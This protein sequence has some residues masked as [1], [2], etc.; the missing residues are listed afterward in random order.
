MK[1]ATALVALFLLAWLSACVPVTPSM[2]SISPIATPNLVESFVNAGSSQATA[3][4]AVS[5]AQF[6][7]GQLTATIQSQQITSTERAWSQTA[8]LQSVELS[9]TQESW[10]ATSM[11][12]IAIATAT[13]ASHARLD[14]WLATATQHAWNIT[15]TTDAA[16]AQTY[17]TKQA[18]ESQ[19]IQLGLERQ[20]E[21]NQT[22]A[23]LPIAGGTIFSLLL[24]VVGFNWSRIRVIQRDAHGDAPLLINVMD[25]LAYDADRHP[26]STAGLL[27]GDAKR[28]PQLTAEAQAATTARD[29][30]ID[31]TTRSLLDRPRSSAPRAQLRDA[32]FFSGELPRIQIVEP[33]QVQPLLGDVLPQIIQDA[34]EDDT[35]TKTSD[36]E[37][38]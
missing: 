35:N 23:F 6:F 29:Q 31:L 36:Q 37:V 18:G 4:A 26:S 1:T 34:V 33:E 14:A 8:T 27:G 16:S 13:A 25:G 20:K 2:L 3:V 12:D 11:A 30:A 24:V 22:V 7:A 19:D 10:R 38:P 17:A 9:G 28:L 21:I 15:A 32:A 5:T